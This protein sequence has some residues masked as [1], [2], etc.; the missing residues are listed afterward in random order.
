MSHFKP[1]S[2][3]FHSLQWKLIWVNSAVILI[4]IFIAGVSVK[5]FA[6]L[7]VND[8]RI[9]GE[10]KN[11]FFNQ[12]MQFYLIR[13]S[14]V[15]IIIAAAV[16]FYFIRKWFLPLRQLAQA[17]RQMTGG[18]YPAPLRVSSTDE[19][20]QLTDAFN[21]LVA[22]L[23]QQEQQRNNM[24]ADIAHDL[25][26]PLTNLNGYLEA[27]H[28][29]DIDGS[30]ALFS[31]LYEE[32]QHLTRLVEQF[33]QLHTWQTQKA[34]MPF[35][36]LSIHDLLHTVLHAFTVSFQKRGI[37]CAS[38]IDEAIIWG[39]EQG[40]KQAVENLIANSILYNE[41]DW[42][43]ISAEKNG[44]MYVIHITNLGTPIPAE[45]SALIF[46]RFYR[47]EPS[48]NR[49]TGGAG[50]GLSIVKEIAAHHQGS[51]SVTSKQN[52]HTFSLVLPLYTDKEKPIDKD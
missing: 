26:T 39:N 2:A 43:K 25:R 37:H 12:T 31:S 32:S 46:E 23:K 13:A 38:S 44:R 19:I 34:S 14:F 28:H 9:V 10:A 51:I 24:I 49:H 29:R 41:S 42:I 47:L 6:C 33:Q 18:T 52:E 20:G 45:Q 35:V 3:L 7:L 21:H 8:F 22:K 36:S 4:V 48:R 50:L 27:L 40:I 16:H 11:A 5:D 17:T 1:Y 15:A 30:P